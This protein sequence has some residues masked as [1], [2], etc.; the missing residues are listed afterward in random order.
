MSMQDIVDKNFELFPLILIYNGGAQRLCTDTAFRHHAS[1]GIA[2]RPSLNIITVEC[3]EAGAG[4]ARCLISE[5]TLHAIVNYELL[6]RPEGACCRYR[7][8]L[9]IAV[10]A[11]DDALQ[12]RPLA[13]VHLDVDGFKVRTREAV[14]C[15][16]QRSDGS[17]ATVAWQ[18]IMGVQV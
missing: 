10:I 13:T 1:Q 15:V 4:E 9:E 6:P 16:D 7:R 18:R 2:S 8:D 14:D 11:K 3:P 17:D 5:E 12:E